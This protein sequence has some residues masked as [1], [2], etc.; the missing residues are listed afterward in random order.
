[1]ALN[2][3]ALD[4]N[5]Y[6]TRHK[7]LWD[8]LKEFQPIPI[9]HCGVMK[10]WMEYQQ[11]ECVIQFLWVLMTHILRV[12]FCWTFCFQSPKFLPWLFK[13][14]GNVQLINVC[15]SPMILRFWVILAFLLLQLPSIQNQN[16]KDLCALIVVFKEISLKN[17]TS[18]TDTH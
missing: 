3:G 18:F 16:E 8:E 11:K 13:K 14:K 12:K 9:C 7:I 10:Y 5:T 4:V 1:M 6:Y 17:V 15:H 2:Q